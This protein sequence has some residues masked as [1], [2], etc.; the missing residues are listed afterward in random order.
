MSAEPIWTK[1]EALHIVHWTA[2]VADDKMTA[3]AAEMSCIDYTSYTSSC[4]A[5]SLP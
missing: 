5:S 1:L 4:V 2:A 3:I